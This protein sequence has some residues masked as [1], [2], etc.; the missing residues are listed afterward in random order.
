M[1]SASQETLASTE[2]MIP[3]IQGQMAM[4]D[5]ELNA[6]EFEIIRMLRP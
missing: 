5:S 4:L 3:K 2:R 6:P 1:Q